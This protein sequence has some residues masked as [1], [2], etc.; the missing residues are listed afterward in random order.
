MANSQLWHPGRPRADSL[1]SSDK[2]CRKPEAAGSGSTQL[3]LREIPQHSQTPTPRLP[4]QP[5]EARQL[6]GPTTETQGAFLAWCSSDLT[7]MNGIQSENLGESQGEAHPAERPHLG[8]GRLL[9]HPPISLHQPGLQ[10]PPP[11]FHHGHRRGWHPGSKSKARFKAEVSPDTRFFFS[12]LHVE[13][14]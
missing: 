3:K 6:L 11:A 8:L 14:Y 1:S 5:E 12:P 2:Q 4:G 13:L 9:R 7:R 10:L